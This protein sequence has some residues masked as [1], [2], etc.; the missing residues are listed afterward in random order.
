MESMGLKIIRMREMVI[1]SVKITNDIMNHRRI[2]HN[3]I[4]R[5]KMKA[6]QVKI[7]LGE[8]YVNFE[9]KG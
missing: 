7:T 5:V 9:R 8:N 2:S 6:F 4:N 1:Y 3:R